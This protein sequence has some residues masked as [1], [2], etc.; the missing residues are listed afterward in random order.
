[1]RCGTRGASCTRGC[2]RARRST[3]AA[4][5]MQSRRTCTQR[6]NAF[7]ASRARTALQRSMRCGA[8]EG[9]CAM[10]TDQRPP[11]P[12]EAIKANSR[13]LRGTIADGL[14]RVETGALSDD[15]QQLTKF[16]GIYLQDDR[17][18]RA[19]RGRKKME[20][21]FSFMARLRVPGGVLTPA[22]WLAAETIARERGNGTLRLTPRQTIQF[23][24][25]IKSNLRLAISG[26][27]DAMLDTIAACGDVNRNVIATANPW[28]SR[29]HAE[30]AA[31]AQ[32]IG[33]HLLPKSRAWHESW[34]AREQHTGGEE[35]DEPIY[36]ARYMP[37]KFKI[38]VALPPHNDVD[39]FAHDLGFIAIREGDRVAGY[40]VVV[41]GGMGM[42]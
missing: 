28:E 34:I 35:E 8:R 4:M 6:C 21:A 10:S 17:D 7:L 15:D 19:E 14:T 12:N 37:R 23:P 42:T 30:V 33:T 20:K 11:S 16:H 38:A 36:G 9:I 41:G 32:A 40:N 39:V 24:R 26:L 22:Q 3:S 2:R 27:N 13:F 29:G 25:I 18:L 5:P 1:M 31:L